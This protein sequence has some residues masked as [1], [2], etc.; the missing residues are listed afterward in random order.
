MIGFSKISN[1]LTTWFHTEEHSFYRILSLNNTH[2]QLASNWIEQFSTALRTLDALHL[3]VA[4]LE[5]LK[6]VTADKGFAKAARYF[7]LDV[8]MID[9][10]Q[11]LSTI[12]E[13]TRL[14]DF[15]KRSIG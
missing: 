14:I 12:Y 9:P 7:G 1:W 15:P 6:L 2:Y 8:D 10:M 4:S 11:E 13:L 5:N 3:A